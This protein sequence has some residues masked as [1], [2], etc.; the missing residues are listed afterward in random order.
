MACA[1][2]STDE[3]SPPLFKLNMDCFHEIFNFLSLDEIIYVG[4]TCTKL[5]RVA[6]DFFRAN[7]VGMCGR[8]ENGAISIATK[9]INVFSQY[10]RK[11]AFYGDRLD[12]FRYAAINCTKATQIRVHGM[13]PTRGFD[14]IRSMLEGIEVL[15]MDECTINYEFYANYLKYCPNLKSLSIARSNQHRDN[16]N[17]VGCNNEWMQRNYKNLKHFELT[18]LR[19]LKPNELIE[20]LKRNPNIRTFTIDARSLWENR[21]SILGSGIKLEKMALDIC[22][23]KMID[24]EN[25][26]ITTKDEFYDLLLA[27]HEREFYKWLHLHILFVDQETLDKMMTLTGLEMIA[28]DIVRIDRPLYD[29][30]VIVVW[31]GDEILNVNHMPNDVPNLERIY[32]HKVI[33]R[34]ILAFIQHSVNLR[35]IKIRHILDQDDF[36]KIDLSQLNDDRNR[37][38]RPCKVSIFLN[39]NIYLAMKWAHDR[40]DFGLIEIKR[41]ES[42]EWDDLSAKSRYFNGF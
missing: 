31:C 28:G 42:Q 9:Q 21:H 13:L 25:A 18:E 6:G 16:P 32:F 22:Q 14:Y 19:E 40:I 1:N 37:L 17:I 4:K 12:A 7:Y 24:S 36:R 29:L 34:R 23:T 30:K 11:I 38:H 35:T 20:F 5:Q 41:Y 39:E 15:E 8:C 3:Q 27:L 33:F 10:M 26:T 2:R